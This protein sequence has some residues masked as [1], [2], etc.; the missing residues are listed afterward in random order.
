MKT[1]GMHE[2]IKTQISTKKIKSLILPTVQNF[3]KKLK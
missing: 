2:N 3:K 1:T